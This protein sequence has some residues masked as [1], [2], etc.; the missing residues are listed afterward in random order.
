MRGFCRYDSEARQLV[1]IAQGWGCISRYDHIV[2]HRRVQAAAGYALKHAAALGGQLGQLRKVLQ[3]DGWLASEQA[4]EQASAQLRRAVKAAAREEQLFGLPG[5]RGWGTGRIVSVWS[6]AYEDMV[7]RVNAEHSA[8]AVAA[9]QRW[10]AIDQCAEDERRRAFQAEEERRRALH[11]RGMGDMDVPQKACSDEG[12]KERGLESQSP[13]PLSP[14][15]SRELQ[16]PSP[17]P[18]PPLSCELP[19]RE[20]PP[21]TYGD[22]S[23]TQLHLSVGGGGASAATAP[24]K[25]REPVYDET[26]RELQTTRIIPSKVRASLP[27]V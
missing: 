7:R 13:P 25:S 10:R 18:S 27:P 14:P 12:D 15:P 23:L 21:L 6:G 22:S 24:S 9:K 4:R 1:Q 19:S 20:P 26:A 16:A 2:M 8:R 17:P 11:A 3:Y 5:A